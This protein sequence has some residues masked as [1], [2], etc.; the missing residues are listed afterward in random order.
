[1]RELGVQ[2]G[3]SGYKMNAEGKVTEHWDVLREVGDAKNAA[4][5]NGMF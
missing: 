5:A 1:M 2:I 3:N 4:R